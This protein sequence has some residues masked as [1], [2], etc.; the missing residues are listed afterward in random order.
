MTLADRIA[1]MKNG[2]IQQLDDPHTIYN[3]PVNLFVAGFIGSPTMNFLKGNFEG[4]QSFAMEG[5]N[6]PIG[7]YRFESPPAGRLE[8]VLGIR[9]EHIAVGDDAAKMPFQF[10]S[11]I[12]IIEPMGSETV[13]YT[14][15][16][17]QI[18]TFRCSADIPLDEGQKVR[19]GFDP[20]RGSMFDAQSGLRV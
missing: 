12:E 7:P 6:V 19:L 2:V 15:I 20:A 10:D 5:M 3:K 1:I 8:G 13:G 9:P 11:E 4:P 16:A 18:L 14:R 17:G